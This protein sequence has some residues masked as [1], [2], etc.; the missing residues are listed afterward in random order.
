MT[1]KDVLQMQLNGSFNLLGGR[2]ES[3]SDEEWTKRGIP[4]SSTPG[5]VIW[6]AARTIDWGVHCAIQG[7]PEIAD[8]PEF[9]ALRADELAYG[10]G[11]TAEE[12]EQAA[13]TIRRDQVRP[14]L[15]ALK[16]AAIGWISEQ[17]DSDLDQ[18]PD[19]KAHQRARPRYLTQPVWDEVSD[20]EGLPAWH[21]LARPCISHIRVHL[22]EIDTLLQA[23]RAKTP[24]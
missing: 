7:I 4:D 10:S 16:A 17:R 15:T 24:V 13:E 20:L 2:L 9:K 5:F 11:I 8:R 14:Y 12:A 18:V 6:H 22:G 3:V 19:F 21:I 1:G 23:I